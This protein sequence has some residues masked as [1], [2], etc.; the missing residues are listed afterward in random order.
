MDLP[1]FRNCGIICSSR[2]QLLPKVPCCAHNELVLRGAVQRHRHACVDKAVS[3]REMQRHVAQHWNEEYTS[4]LRSWGFEVGKSSPCNFRHAAREITMTVHGDDF[5][6][7][8]TS[9]HL[10]WLKE[11]MESKY[12]IQ[13]EVLGPEPGQDKDAPGR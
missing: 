11:R 3:G 1:C 8:G 4:T 10:N 12:D 9:H 2:G 13:M 7:V 5:A 6:V